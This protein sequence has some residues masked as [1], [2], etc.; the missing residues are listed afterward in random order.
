MPT[1]DF[2][3]LK[4]V[5][6]HF[7]ITFAVFFCVVIEFLYLCTSKSNESRLDVTLRVFTSV[8]YAGQV[9]T[10]VSKRRMTDAFI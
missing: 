3:D 2:L 8:C 1:L 7:A 9:R 10:Y 5:D 4:R 6:S